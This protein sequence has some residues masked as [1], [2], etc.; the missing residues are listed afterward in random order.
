MTTVEEPFE[1]FPDRYDEW[2]ERHPAAYRSELDAVR[3][4]LPEPGPVLEVGVGT[5]RFA[6]PLGVRFGLD[7]ARAMARRA[8]QR[9]VLV[10]SGI[11][12]QLPFREG[13]FETVL[14]AL[15]L[16]FFEQPKQA[17]SEARRVLRPEGSLVLAFL[18]PTSPPAEKYRSRSG[19]P[20]YEGAEFRNPSE[21]G[22]LLAETGFRVVR[23]VQTLTRLPEEMDDTEPPRPGSGRGLFVAVDARPLR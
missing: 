3:Q 13:S 12:E 7:P 8:R 19:G 20:F 11:G 17:L 2:Y 21:V 23:T 6:A 22:R 18:D 14:I 4:L 15:T 16:C 9:G 5:A 1:Q 10:V